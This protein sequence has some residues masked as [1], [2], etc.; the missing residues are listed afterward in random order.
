[1]SGQG[2]KT[3]V[4]DEIAKRWNWGAFLIP[5]L[6]GPWHRA[7]IVFLSVPLLI[8][9][10]L[11]PLVAP[12]TGLLSLAF[13]VYLGKRG[14]AFAWQGH[15]WS[16]FERFRQIQRRWTW[17]ALGLIGIGLVASV[18][19]TAPPG[20]VEPVTFHDHGV[21]FEYPGDWGHD[22]GADAG[23]FGA[24]APRAAW[25]EAFLYDDDDFIF[26]TAVDLPFV[27]DDGNIEFFQSGVAKFLPEG[28]TVMSGPEL[29]D[30]PWY[31]AS[32]W[33]IHPSGAPEATTRLEYVWM[34]TRG[35][36]VACQSSPGNQAAIAEACDGVLSTLRADAPPPVPLGWTA[37]ASSE[38][39]FAF[40]VP[41]GWS[42]RPSR[43]PEHVVR[44]AFTQGPGAAFPLVTVVEERI[45]AGESSSD[46][47]D[48]TFLKAV[49]ARSFTVLE[50]GSQ[51]IAGRDA[52]VVTGKLGAPGDRV[53]YTVHIS[54]ADGR[55]GFTFFFIAGRRDVELTTSTYLAIAETLTPEA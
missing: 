45:A 31:P 49:G 6:W 28:T 29:D 48:R 4:P 27:V 38:A 16:S 13:A 30:L 54:I 23:L 11:W 22:E 15:H 14:S 41:T 25:S 33:V 39:R 17:L 1:M 55:R 44:A 12:L 26:M 20:D 43:D 10:A 42:R 8:A 37:I 19:A 50:R 47:A 40:A 5:L 51:T 46:L 34:G 21:S 35:V 9:G 32:R 52:E 2:R 24:P 36:L 3:P 7:W 18:A 53:P